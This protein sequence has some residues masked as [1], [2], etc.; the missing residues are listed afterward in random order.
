LTGNGKRG[1]KGKEKGTYGFMR[2]SGLY[3]CLVV[4]NMENGC[5]H[6]RHTRPLLLRIYERAGEIEEEVGER[7]GGIRAR[8]QGVVDFWKRRRG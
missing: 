1:R 4:E 8:K 6:S 3:C 2:A 5:F 7:E